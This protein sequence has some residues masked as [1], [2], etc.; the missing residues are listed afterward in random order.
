MLGTAVAAW[1]EK[2]RPILG[3]SVRRNGDLKLVRWRSLP[4]NDIS[5]I[6]NWANDDQQC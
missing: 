4:M 6:E 5:A 2:A 3:I 1:R